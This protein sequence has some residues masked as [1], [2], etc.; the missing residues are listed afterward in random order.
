MTELSPTATTLSPKLAPGPTWPGPPQAPLNGTNA[1]SPI[2]RKKKIAPAACA[3]GRSAACNRRQV[4]SPGPVWR[5]GLTRGRLRSLVCGV[6][7]ARCEGCSS[8][9]L[10][11]QLGSPLLY[12]AEAPCQVQQ[13][14]QQADSASNI[15]ILP[16]IYGLLEYGYHDAFGHAYGDAYGPLRRRSHGPWPSPTRAGSSR[17]AAGG[18]VGSRPWSRP[19]S[20]ARAAG[21]PRGFPGRLSATHP[22]R[23]L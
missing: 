21:P 17:P 15:G 6:G 19:W 7:E 11:C 8:C 12:R 5:G 10:C 3:H 23:G 20:W 22:P 4:L 16:W 2:S 1:S 9:C 14:M 18:A 13:A